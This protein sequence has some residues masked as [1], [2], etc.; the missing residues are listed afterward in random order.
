MAVVIAAMASASSAHAQ[1]ALVPFATGAVVEHRISTGGEV[2]RT[3]GAVWGAGASIGLSDWLGVTGRLGSGNLS[4]RTP[5]AESREYS[6][7]EFAIVLTPDRWLTVDIGTVIRTMETPLAR[8][9]WMEVRAGSEVGLDL[10]DGVLRATAHLSISPWVSVSGHPAPD[11]A[12]GA[13]SAL[14][15]TDRRLVAT[16][17]YSL[18]RYDFPTQAA[19]RRLEQRSSLMARI[20]WRLR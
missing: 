7:A 4:A 19:G 3:A 5:Q 9:R 14:Q 15:Y 2:E 10:V 17:A 16:L 18:D 6:E 13:G 20:G 12:L 8:Q 11:L 1:R